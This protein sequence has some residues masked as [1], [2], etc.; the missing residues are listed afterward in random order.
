MYKQ[1]V[2][3]D[4]KGI[5]QFDSVLSQIVLTVDHFKDIAL[6]EKEQRDKDGNTNWDVHIVKSILTNSAHFWSPP[7]L[8]T[9][10]KKKALISMR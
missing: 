7:S 10:S 9:N 2:F 1:Q 5:P 6:K 3:E 4:L 8:S